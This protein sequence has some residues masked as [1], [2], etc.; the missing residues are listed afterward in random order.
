MQ[1]QV[2]RRTFLTW[3]ALETVSLTL[4]CPF[5]SD[6]DCVTLHMKLQMV[7]SMSDIN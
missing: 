7:E 3:Y 6:N 5:D 2:N 1:V 4:E